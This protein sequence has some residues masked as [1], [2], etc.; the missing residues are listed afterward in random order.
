[1]KPFLSRPTYGTASNK[2]CSDR[3]RALRPVSPV[4]ISM[5]VFNCDAELVAVKETV[6]GFE[7]SDIS[8]TDLPD[9]MESK[10]NESKVFLKHGRFQDHSRRNT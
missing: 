5:D 7:S 3:S 6:N 8:I 4:D 1:M 10:L 2:L 9:T